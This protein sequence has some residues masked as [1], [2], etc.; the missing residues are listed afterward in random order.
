MENLS[1]SQRIKLIEALLL[2]TGKPMNLEQLKKA[3]PGPTL[4]LGEV[5]GLLQELMQH[6]QDRGIQLVEVASG[7][8]FQVA[9]EVAKWIPEMVPDKTSRFSRAFME[10]LALIAYRQPITRSEIEN[11]RGVSI[12]SHIIKTLQE[13]E[14]VRIVGYKEVPGKPALYASTKK[15]LDFFNLTSLEQLPPLAQ[16]KELG[17]LDE[18]QEK[19]AANMQHPAEAAAKL[20][21]LADEAQAVSMDETGAAIEPVTQESISL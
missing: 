13:L 16:L 12:S 2:V 5:R 11:V 9:A 15:F 6:Y 19:F 8:R 1:N 21:E 20:T 4:P 10:T 17:Q 3:I 7:Y 14:W 18:L